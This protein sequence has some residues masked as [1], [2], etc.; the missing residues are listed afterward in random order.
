MVREGSDP[1]SL[2][3]WMR[4]HEFMYIFFLLETLQYMIK[5]PSLP[6]NFDQS[7]KQRTSTVPPLLAAIPYYVRPALL[8]YRRYKCHLS[9]LKK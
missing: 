9:G 8:T 5:I 4:Q 7:R 1:S 6:M 3:Q 2:A